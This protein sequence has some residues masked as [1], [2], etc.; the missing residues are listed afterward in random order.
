[1]SV[2]LFVFSDVHDLER[3]MDAVPAWGRCG[4]SAKRPSEPTE[5]PEN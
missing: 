5:W 3:P 2:R 1:M 4:T